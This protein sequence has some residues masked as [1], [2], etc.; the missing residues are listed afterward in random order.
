MCAIIGICKNK[1]L[2]DEDVNNLEKISKKQ[3][4][5]GPDQYSNWIDPEKKTLLLHRRLSINDLSDYGVQP[6]ISHSRRYIIVFNGE[7]YNFLNL[8]KKLRFKKLF[9]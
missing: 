2:T 4:H 5:R 8:K 9:I 1:L 7:I 3:K 6:M